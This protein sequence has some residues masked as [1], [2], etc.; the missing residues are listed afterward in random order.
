[1]RDTFP[2]AGE[3]IQ[4]AGDILVAGDIQAVDILEAD[5]DIAGWEGIPEVGI[6]AESIP[7]GG[8]VGYLVARDR[9]KDCIHLDS[10]Y[11]SF[12]F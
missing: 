6:P 12:I 9:C 7:A 1:M 10:K 11:Q 4:A 5:R 3:D 2:T 8:K